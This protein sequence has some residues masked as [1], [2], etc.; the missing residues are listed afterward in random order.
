MKTHYNDGIYLWSGNKI[1]R[2]K[3]GSGD[4][5]FPHY[6]INEMGSSTYWNNVISP[7][8]TFLFKFSFEN[9]KINLIRSMNINNR[10]IYIYNCINI[11]NSKNI[12]TLFLTVVLDKKPNEVYVGPTQIEFDLFIK[13]IKEF[14]KNVPSKVLSKISTNLLFGDISAFNYVT[15]ALNDFT[16]KKI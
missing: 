3:F 1:E 9:V 6:C 12:W 7:A 16:R 15:Y 5:R 10:K 8:H 13:F 4:Y 14:D 11:T 2:L